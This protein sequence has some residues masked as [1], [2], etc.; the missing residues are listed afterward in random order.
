MLH[1]Q[2]VATTKDLYSDLIVI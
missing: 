1:F 2:A